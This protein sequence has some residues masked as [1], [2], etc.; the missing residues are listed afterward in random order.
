MVLS[1][2]FIPPYD[3]CGRR[4]RVAIRST[5]VSRGVYP[6]PSQCQPRLSQYAHT[7]LQKQQS[8]LLH[9]DAFR[10]LIQEHIQ[11]PRDDWDNF[12]ED[13]GEEQPSISLADCE[14]RCANNTE[15]MQYSYQPGKC[16]T[17]KIV[18]RGISSSGVH[19]A[20]MTDRINA[21]LSKLGSCSTAKW[22][23]K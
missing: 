4:A 21:T 2:G 13:G 14:A 7:Q 18:K 10:E 6:I 15:C 17:S 22:V 16:L 20:W 3:S 9:S 19:S 11:A 12:S 8:L 1:C 23:L 5:L